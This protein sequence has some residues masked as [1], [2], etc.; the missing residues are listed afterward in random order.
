MVIKI[1]YAVARQIADH[2]AS[3]SPYEACGLLAGAVGHISRAFPL[4][5]AAKS[6]ATQYC[7]EPIEELGALKAID[8]A[9]LDWLGVYHSHPH[10]AP[11]PSPE[12][13]KAAVDQRLLHLIVSLEG[14]KPKLKLWHLEGSSVLPLELVFDSETDIEPASR[15]STRQQV[16]IIIAGIASLLIL[17]A[18][19]F[20]LLPPAPELTPIP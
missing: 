15:L 18:I 19:S 16:A 4:K 5:N 9:G 1:A 10:S 8:A 6:P 12:D 7:L 14:A 2:A 13:I 3:E 20:T 17:L 11:I